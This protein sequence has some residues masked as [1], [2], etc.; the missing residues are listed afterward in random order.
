[1][2]PYA[3]SAMT[4]KAVGDAAGEMMQ[5][6]IKD[7]DRVGMARAKQELAGGADADPTSSTALLN[8][9]VSQIMT[10]AFKSQP[11]PPFK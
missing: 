4:M 5:F 7:M 2:L 3:F 6:V 1:M 8:K 11:R 9:K 10:V